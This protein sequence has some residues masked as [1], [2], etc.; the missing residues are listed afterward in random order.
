MIGSQEDDWLTR[1]SADEV[2]FGGSCDDALLGLRRRWS[3]HIMQ[4]WWSAWWLLRKW[5]PQMRSRI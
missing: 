4:W 5:R 3:S 2:I 1:T